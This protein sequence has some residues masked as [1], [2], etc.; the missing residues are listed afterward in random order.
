MV[1]IKEYVPTLIEWD[2]LVL[3]WNRSRTVLSSTPGAGDTARLA[4][5]TKQFID[6]H[7]DAVGRAV[8]AWLAKNLEIAN[9]SA[10]PCDTLAGTAWHDEPTVVLTKRARGTLHEHVKTDPASS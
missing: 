2:E 3:L 1:E 7:P 6:A 9:G 5:T 10:S 4:W 8:Y